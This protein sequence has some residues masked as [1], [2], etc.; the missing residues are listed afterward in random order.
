MI[1]TSRRTEKLVLASRGSRLALTQAR[2]VVE[3]IAN[4]HPEVQV[5]IQVVSTTGDRDQ[6]PF[7]EIGGKGLFSGEVERSVA[8]GACDL[9]AHS[10]KDLTAELAEGCVLGAFLERGPVHDVVVGGE[11]SSG[12][13]RLLALGAGELVGTSSMRRRSLVAEL[14]DDLKLV[15]LRGNIDTRLAKVERGDV[16]VAIL[17]AA[18]IE[19]LGL[20]VNAAGLD[21]G[22]WVPAPAQGAI[23][24]EAQADRTDVLEILQSIDHVGSRAE[25][26]CE[27][28]FAERLEGGCSVPLGCLARADGKGLVATA[29]LGYPQGGE[30]LRDRISGPSADAPALGRELAVALLEAGGDEILASLRGEE[31]PEPQQ[32]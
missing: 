4:A 28:A 10:A 1:S 9:A 19:R 2:L 11:G 27:R 12:E 26:E 22:R 25:I 20:N 32:P 8:E 21:P 7:G 31:V 18:G 23:A 14:R 5:E 17:A 6:R 24:I 30:G 15:E 13:Q 29:F 16:A 3:A